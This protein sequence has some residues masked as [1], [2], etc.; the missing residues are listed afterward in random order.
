MIKPRSTWRPARAATALSLS[1]AK[2]LCP[3]EGPLAG[4][5]GGG[6]NVYIVADQSINTLQR[7][8]RQVHFRAERGKHGGGTKKAGATGEDLL[9]SVPVGTIARIAE[10]DE[11]VADLVGDGQ[12]A[13]VARGRPRGARKRC[14]QERTQ[15]SAPPL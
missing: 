14:L 15:P 3:W 13:L 8:R 10:T 1:A 12:Q 11:V 4:T 6:G 2:S 7:F 9:I 5:A